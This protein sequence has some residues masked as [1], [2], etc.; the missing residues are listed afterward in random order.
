M[1]RFQTDGS[2]VLVEM[3]RR[4]ETMT[5]RN[6][7]LQSNSHS[8]PWRAHYPRSTRFN[9]G[10]NH[11]STLQTPILHRL[12]RL[13]IF[14]LQEIPPSLIC[15]RWRRQADVKLLIP[16]LLPQKD[17][18]GI[19][20]RASATLHIRL[21]MWFLLRCSHNFVI[22]RRSRVAQ[23]VLLPPHHHPR[24]L[25]PQVHASVLPIFRNS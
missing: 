6:L 19:I 16:F 15:W 1:S 18:L 5:Y 23:H 12:P 7:R 20:L 9:L 8:F 10:F 11:H 17:R 4:D 14:R 22:P 21:P 13:H 24:D 3:P 2:E 25:L